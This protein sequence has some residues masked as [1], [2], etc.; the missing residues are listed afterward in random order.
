MSSVSNHHAKLIQFSAFLDHGWGHAAVYP[1]WPY[2]LISKPVQSSHNGVTSTV[3]D[4]GEICRPTISVLGNDLHQYIHYF[5]NLL[6]A[7][8][9]L[10]SSFLKHPLIVA[11][12]I[13]LSGKMWI[14]F[15]ET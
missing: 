2:V 3:K 11:W 5:K 12:L 15:S 1:C 7:S 9:A 13:A 10:S 8:L 4:L 14:K 6:G